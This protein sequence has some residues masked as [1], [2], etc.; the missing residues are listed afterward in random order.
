MTVFI[1]KSEESGSPSKRRLLND[2]ENTVRY[3]T[4]HEKYSYVSPDSRKRKRETIVTAVVSPERT[5]KP[6][7]YFDS[8]LF[9]KTCYESEKHIDAHKRYINEEI[10]SSVYEQAL[11]DLEQ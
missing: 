7:S 4:V 10:F 1:R 9:F 8:P 2:Y 3:N 11:N 5:M 6:F